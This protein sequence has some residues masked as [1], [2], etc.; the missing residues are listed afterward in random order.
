LVKLPVQV[1]WTFL[2]ALI[3]D[4]VVCTADVAALSSLLNLAWSRLHVANTAD[5]EGISGPRA[6]G[7]A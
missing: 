4:W 2:L 5:T 1:R 3:N 7:H 6:S